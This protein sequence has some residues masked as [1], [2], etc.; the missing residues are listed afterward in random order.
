MPGCSVT[1]P[2]DFYGRGVEGGELEVV[3]AGGA[4]IGVGAGLFGVV[5]W[6]LSMSATVAPL[7]TKRRRPRPLL[8]VLNLQGG[9][10]GGKQD[11]LAG[12]MGRQAD[13]AQAEI[14]RGDLRKA[15]AVGKPALGLR[16]RRA[17]QVIAGKGVSGVLE[18]E[19]SIA[20]AGLDVGAEGAGE[21]VG[22]GVGIAELEDADGLRG[23]GRELVQRVEE[24]G[25][26]GGV[27]EGLGRGGGGL[28]LHRYSRGL[29]RLL[30]LC[31]SLRWRIAAVSGSGRKLGVRERGFAGT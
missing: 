1:R 23:V 8:Q 27:E 10:G 31:G 3:R 7:S 21:H 17:G 6:R 28:Y 15:V 18:A 29:L 26:L 13:A 9:A 22:G 20:E 14:G 2:E 5:R 30:W 16:A 12:A 11:V 19:A 24:G 4:G 25:E